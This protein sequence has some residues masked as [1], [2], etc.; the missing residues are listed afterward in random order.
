MEI[1]A[2]RGGAALAPEN[3]ILAAK[4]GFESKAD[5]WETDISVTKDGRL[6]LVHDDTLV[7][8]TD[9]VK[10]FP[11]KSPWRTAD[12]S[13]NEIRAL[14]AGSWFIES[15]PFSVIRSGEISPEE[16]RCFRGI[17]IPD[18]EEALRF[19]EFTD[20]AVNLEIK[21]LPSVQAGFPIAAKIIQAIRNTGIHKDRVRISSFDHQI[22]R[23]IRTIDPE[24]RLH[25]LIGDHTIHSVNRDQPEFHT[26][27]IDIALMDSNLL[28]SAR[29]SGVV[30]N[31]YTVNT[32]D[33]ARRCLENGVAGIFT[34]FPHRMKRYA[35]PDEA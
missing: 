32:P 18:V 24:I 29:E 7:R 27:N 2:H 20:W 23:D 1:I 33:E 31:A 17:T 6:I 34:D 19:T 16:C 10:R 8:T 12:F 26:W 35:L 25:A 3:T 22:L 28:R 9:A 5:L 4:K 13:F 15:D 14:D 11:E 21:A 30:I